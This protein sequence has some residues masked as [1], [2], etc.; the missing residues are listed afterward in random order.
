MLALGSETVDGA[1]TADIV[2]PRPTNCAVLDD[3]ERELD[4]ALGLS[5]TQDFMRC[6]ELSKLL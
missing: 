1:V 2:R 6:T 5:D 4:K 3:G